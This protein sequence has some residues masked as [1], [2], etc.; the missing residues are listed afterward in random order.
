[1]IFL[2]N[3]FLFICDCLLATFPGPCI[4]L[5]T[6]SSNRQTNTVTNSTV[7]TDVHQAFD[8]HLHG[9]SELTFHL[10]T[11]IHDLTDLA[12]LVVIPVLDLDIPV[13]TSF[14]EDL[15]GGTSSDSENVGQPNLTPFVLR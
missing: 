14:I 12:H 13:N 2:F 1:M 4:V 11:F 8:V 15:L 3:C 10:V 5:G 7:G 6:L 9:G